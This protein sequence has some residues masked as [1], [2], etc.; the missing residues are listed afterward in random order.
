MFQV[1]IEPI[2]MIMKALD[3]LVIERLIVPKVGLTNEDS[4]DKNK[5]VMQRAFDIGKNVT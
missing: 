3:I 2:N 4:V 1:T 5:E